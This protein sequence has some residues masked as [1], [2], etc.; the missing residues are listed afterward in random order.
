M[1]Q[2]FSHAAH[3]GLEA[4]RLRERWCERG[5]LSMDVAGHRNVK[6][7][8]SSKELT[9]I[10]PARP[11]NK[12]AGENAAYQYPTR[13]DNLRECDDKSVSGNTYMRKSTRG[14]VGRG[15]GVF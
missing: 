12:V 14:R 3:G 5:F 13:L 10:L 8:T 15:C 7:S 11:A 2:C 4:K 1:L 9:N 6:K